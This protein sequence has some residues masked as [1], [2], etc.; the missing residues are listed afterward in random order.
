MLGKRV[1]VSQQPT[2]FSKTLFLFYEAELSS[3]SVGGTSFA[4]LGDHANHEALSLQVLQSLIRVS[5][6]STWPLL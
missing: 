3:G 5:A 1:C 6:C 2:L 4:V